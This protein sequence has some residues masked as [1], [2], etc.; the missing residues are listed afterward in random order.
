MPL[1]R[2][3]F[4]R[5]CPSVVPIP[6][7]PQSTHHLILLRGLSISFWFSLLL[8]W[9]FLSYLILLALSPLSLHSRKQKEPKHLYNEEFP[10][11]SLSYRKQP[12]NKTGL[13]HLSCAFL[14]CRWFCVPGINL[15][16]RSSP[17]KRLVLAGTGR[18]IQ[19]S[20]C[21][22]LFLLVAGISD[23]LKA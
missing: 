20:A 12:N 11:S 2:D 22:T 4:P 7:I 17:S 5:P 8:Y 18:Q 15:V 6:P 10:S 14:S 9:P 1:E 21:Q 19:L 16:I 3:P 23:S 13:N